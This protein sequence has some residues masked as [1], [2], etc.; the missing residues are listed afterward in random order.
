MIHLVLS[1][2][3]AAAAAPPATHVEIYSPWSAGVLRSDLKVVEKAAGNC[4]TS[5]LTTDRSDAWRC[6]RGN[7]I[8]DPCFQGKPHATVVA[9]SENPFSNHVTL[10]TLKKP[11]PGGSDS[12]TRMLQPEGQPWALQLV[13]G[14][15]C[16]FV[17]GAT[18]V[19]GGMRMNSE[20]K[21]DNWIAGFPN[22]SK[23]AWSAHLLVWPNK[24]HLKQVGIAVAVF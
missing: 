3:V 8:L 14:E 17:S 7:E 23:P 10:L 24:S 22:R 15:R 13:D 9:C 19:A 2:L 16:Y 1:A 12:T 5:S 4:W 21:G 20:C 18:D 11:L 6:M